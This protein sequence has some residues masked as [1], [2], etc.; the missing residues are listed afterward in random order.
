MSSLRIVPLNDDAGLAVNVERKLKE[1]F[2]G[3]LEKQSTA[4]WY[5][6]LP[7]S[8]KWTMADADFMNDLADKQDLLAGWGYQD[9]NKLV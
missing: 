9:F 5:L 2:A 8:Y 1:R 3:R 7:A 6:L 4:L